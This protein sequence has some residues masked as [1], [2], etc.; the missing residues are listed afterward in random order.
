VSRDNN[1]IEVFQNKHNVFIVKNF[2][3]LLA[4]T[5]ENTAT[6]LGLM[7]KEFMNDLR[8]LDQQT[9]T[10][11]QRIKGYRVGLRIITCVIVITS[12]SIVSSLNVGVFSEISNNT[13]Y[14]SLMLYFLV[15]LFMTHL[16]IELFM[17]YTI[18]RKL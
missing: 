4:V 3:F 5:I 9:I 11:R 15:L 12:T 16:L 14:Q 17:N 1:A 7:Y 6:D 8:V 10:L 2:C 13:S 18:R